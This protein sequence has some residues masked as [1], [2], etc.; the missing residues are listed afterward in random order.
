MKMSYEGWILNIH[1]QGDTTH[2][3]LKD[4]NGETNH[5][6][7]MYRPKLYVDVL[8]DR[9]Q[10]KRQLNN[11]PYIV[12]VKFVQRFRSSDELIP[13]VVLE[14]KIKSPKYFQKV[15]ED[16]RKNGHTLFNSD[17]HPREKFF[18]DTNSFAFGLCKINVFDTENFEIIMFDHSRQIIYEIPNC[19]VL[20]L[21]C[22]T[23]KR[24]KAFSHWG[25]LISSIN[26]EYYNS[27]KHME[28]MCDL[29]SISL[30]EESI[31]SI[32]QKLYEHD[33]HPLFD[34]T[35]NK[36]IELL[37][38]TTL[39]VEKAILELLHRIVEK[40]DPDF[41]MVFDGDQFTINYLSHRA[42]FHKLIPNFYLGRIPHK[43]KG[44]EKIKSQSY[45]SYGQVLS[46]NQ[47]KYIPG[48]IHLDVN[49]SFFYK[50]SGLYGLIELTRL[51]GT[52][53]DRCS[54]N[55][56]GTVL[57]AIEFKVANSTI[58]PILIPEG[59]AKGEIFKESDL[60]LTA[61]NGGITYPAHPGIYEQVWGIDFTSLY[62]SLMLKYNIS[63]ETVLCECC[64]DDPNRI[65]VP[66]VNYH[67][68]IK[69]KGVVPRTMEII[70]EKRLYYKYSKGR[71][72]D[73]LIKKHLS[74]IDSALKWILVSCFGYLG[75]KNAR[76]GSIESHQCVT[77]YA[78]RHL[79]VAQQIAN[80][81]G[82]QTI[83]G[84][85]DS[86]YI[87]ATIPDINN[88]KAVKAL[89]EEISQIT[90]VAMNLDG[91]FNWIVFSNI[92]NHKD[93]SALNRYFGAFCTEENKIRGIES[94]KRSTTPI[95]K[96][97]Q[98]QMLQHLSKQKTKEDFLNSIP[99]IT[100]I[101][102][103]YQQRIINAKV[104]PNDLKMKIKST[105]GSAGYKVQS[106]QSSAAHSY[107]S[108]G[109]QLEPGQTMIYIV[110]N[111]RR[112]GDE[113]VTINPEIT[114]D[115]EYDKEWYCELLERAYN[116]LLET[117]QFQ[118]FGENKY[119]Q[120]GRQSEFSEFFD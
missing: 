22:L 13:Q 38:N 104:N 97:M 43:M 25:D 45:F 89:T 71:C 69:Q 118:S 49:N 63:S 35:E 116:D 73:Q 2:L 96:E 5:L 16:L 75:F 86:L 112:Q 95:V 33:D 58:P 39:E 87:Q 62:P 51:S 47:P 106:L 19:S 31:V 40:N 57:T 21:E 26:I 72:V 53:P 32:T 110:R 93:I 111:N 119:N 17:L 42:Q 41:L 11:H 1:Y 65:I 3:W 99:D 109:K 37:G 100:K 114:S 56:I 18:Q 29:Q 7:L 84:L 48:R 68:C 92:K 77:A 4:L 78:R 27:Y 50:D 85:T 46:R 52:P 30:N 105:R 20:T 61:D 23:D 6:K 76:W 113:R 82:Y 91:H 67:I 8:S 80:K 12:S 9:I 60:L 59:K 66:E 98:S 44:E 34:N 103:D 28:D 90:G 15:V 36:R 117:V 115:S 79:I 83:A 94:R 74:G 107:K 54:R 120:F 108:K 14:L 101:L 55:T 24:G 10:Q 88:I 81:R 70:M 102:V 64:K